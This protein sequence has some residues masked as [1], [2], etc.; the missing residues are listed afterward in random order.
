[1]KEAIQ[2]LHKCLA[3][4]Q[5]KGIFDRQQVAYMKEMCDYVTS[6][7]AILHIAQFIKI[8]LLGSSKKK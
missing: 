4:A 1:M 7:E 2:Q 5:R 3:E 6:S 8:L